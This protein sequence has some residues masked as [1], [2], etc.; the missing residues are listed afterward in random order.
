[1]KWIGGGAIEADKSR[2]KKKKK[3]FANCNG[4]CL[5]FDVLKAWG[6]NN[7]NFFSSQNKILVSL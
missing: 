2:I 5:Q 6:A 7:L 3:G 4:F 1:M